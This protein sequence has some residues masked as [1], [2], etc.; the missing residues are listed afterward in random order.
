MCVIPAEVHIWP[1]LLA[2]QLEKQ[3]IQEQR[4]EVNLED[5]GMFNS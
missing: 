1:I 4:Q 5:E 3:D 2:K